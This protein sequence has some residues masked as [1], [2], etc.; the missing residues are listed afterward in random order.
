MDYVHLCG[1]PGTGARSFAG[2][3]ASARVPCRRYVG[4]KKGDS[5]RAARPLLG[6]YVALPSDPAAPLLGPRPDLR[7]AA[8]HTRQWTTLESRLARPQSAHGVLLSRHGEL[9]TDT[10]HGPGQP[11]AH[12][13]EGSRPPGRPCLPARSVWSVQRRQIHRQSRTGLPR[14]GRLGSRG[15]VYWVWTFLLGDEN[16]LELSRGYVKCC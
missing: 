6:G 16:I 1:G 3:G 12:V 5:R 13:R 2:R 8:H 7:T 11:G 9:G 14:T 4:I 10:C 15:T